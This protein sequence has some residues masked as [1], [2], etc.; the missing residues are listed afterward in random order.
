MCDD[1][2]KAPKMIKLLYKHVGNWW[3]MIG[4]YYRP[5]NYLSSWGSEFIENR[6]NYTCSKCTTGNLELII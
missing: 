3:V 4:P 5:Y 6:P 1:L 2:N